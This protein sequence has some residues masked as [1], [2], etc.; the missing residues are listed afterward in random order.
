MYGSTTKGDAVKRCDCILVYGSTTK[1]DAVKRSDCILV[2]GS[3][4]KGNIVKRSD[5]I[6][7]YMNEG[8]WGIAIGVIKTCPETSQSTPRKKISAM[9]SKRPCKPKKDAAISKK[10][11]YTHHIVGVL[12]I[13][14]EIECGDVMGISLLCDLEGGWAQ[15]HWF[16][17]I[18]IQNC[19]HDNGRITNIAIAH[20]KSEVVLAP[21]I[22]EFGSS[23]H[24]TILLS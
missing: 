15:V 10:S 12:V 22:V 23:E 21:E 6:L 9:S 14:C 5:C 2:Y 17:I 3:T 13:I 4:T 7:V 8:K 19:N 20:H 11:L 24:C 1:G 18:S 16:F